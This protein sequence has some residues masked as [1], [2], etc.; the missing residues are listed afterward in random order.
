[1]PDFN[2]K[3]IQNLKLKIHVIEK[4]FL[5]GV[6][7][8]VLCFY[9]D[10]NISI[11]Y[12]AVLLA[13]LQILKWRLKKQL[14]Q[15]EYVAKI[16]EERTIQLRIQRD[17]VMKESEKLSST[18]EALAKAQDELVRQERMVTVGQL[19]KGLVD[20]I[21]NPLN[22]INNFASL[23]VDLLKEVKQELIGNKENLPA[24][25]YEENCEILAML[26]SNLT[27]ITEHGANTVR[28][29]KAMEELLKD[30]Q[31]N[32][33]EADINNLC[34]VDLEVITKTFEKEIR[35]NKIKIIFHGL[36]HPVFTE[37]NIEQMSKVILNITK[38]SM[39]ALL[40]K[41][42]KEKYDPILVVKLEAMGAYVY[43][44]VYDNGIGIEESIKDRIFEPFFTNKPTAEAAGTGLYLRREI[45]LTHKG[46]ISVK[47]EKDNY[48]EFIISI[49]VQQNDRNNE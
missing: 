37:I 40:K 4:I 30:R 46:T 1:M 25:V 12:V 26:N 17:Q 16:V 18:L 45:I 33:V 11:G 34:K 42:E 36:S 7:F 5:G 10:W 48:T 41:A 13:I 29:V 35:E 14:K 28:I 47:S 22:Y 2:I 19:T 44:S 43:I 21:L 49:P 39:Y 38:N 6:V 3:D 27:K 15:K 9:F 20:R 31:G 8:I 23:S 24:E 32:M